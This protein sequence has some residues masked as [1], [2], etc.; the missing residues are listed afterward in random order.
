[1][2][3]NYSN[4]FRV[5][6]IASILVAIT[7]NLRILLNEEIINTGYWPYV[8]VNMGLNYGEFSRWGM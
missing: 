6:D 2:Y 4:K 7:V 8:R 3:L 5:E 1:V